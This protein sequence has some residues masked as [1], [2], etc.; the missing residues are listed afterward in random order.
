MAEPTQ[1]ATLKIQH[2]A[3]PLL[4]LLYLVV[5]L[6]HAALA[7][8]TTGPDE[9]AHYEYARFIAEH[10]R[11]PANPAERG[12]AGYK[13]DQPPLF[14]LIAALPA[15]W[16]DP[17]GPPFLKRV[18]DHPRRQLIERTRHA[19]GLYNTEDE[20]WPYRGE[21]LRWHVG[22][23]VAILFGAATV[24]VT[25]FTARD[26]FKELLPPVGDRLALGAAAVVAF[27]PR[28]ALTGS[29]LNYETTLAF[30]AALYVWLLVR[31]A[32]EGMA[33]GP[34]SVAN[35]RMANGR[36]A[37]EQP[38]ESPIPLRYAPSGG[39]IVSNLPIS[40]SPIPLLLLGLCLGLAITAK[41]SALIL[42]LETMAALWLFKRYY[43]GSWRRWLRSLLIT[44]VAALPAAGWWFGFIIYRFNTIAQDG[45]WVGLLRPLIAADASDA[46]T[47]QLLSFL[48]GGQA[49]FSGAGD[50]LDIGPPW[51]WATTLFRTFWVAGIETHT[52]LGRPGLLL[53]LGLCLLAAYGLFMSW[54]Q[55]N[56]RPPTAGR[57]HQ[58]PTLPA[59]RSTLSQSQLLLALLLLHCAAA[60]VFP[61]IR[62]A[63]TFSLAD[64]AQGRH[65]LFL[66]APAF[67][68][69]LVWGVAG[70]RVAG[71][72]VAGSRVAGS[73]VAGSRVAGSKVAGSRVA[74]SRLLP[75]PYS[76]LPTP[77]SLLPTPYSSLLPPLFL[78]LW[79]GVQLWTMSWAYLPP[80]PVSTR[81]EA[82]TQVERR[83]DQA[84]N[85]AV[86]LVGY[87][88]QQAGSLLRLDLLWQA[89]AV[90]P[91]DYL[92]Q[93]SLLDP[94]G[95][96]AAQWLGYPAAGR[97]PSRAWDVGDLVRDTVWLSL[98]GLEAGIYRLEVQLL[99]ATLRQTAGVRP[100]APVSMGEFNLQAQ[101]PLSSP[102]FQIWRQGRPVTTPQTFHYRETILVTLE[103]GLAQSERQVNIV[104]AQPNLVFEPVRD[105]GDALLFQVGP[106]WPSGS[107]AV[108]V[109]PG[110]RVSEP[111]IQVV[112][113]WQ[114]RF[115]PPA[116]ARP[117]EANFANQVKLLG[118]ELGANRV[119]PGGGIPLTL[120]WQGLDWLGDDYTIFVKLLAADQ[121]VHGGRDRL[122]Q[123]GYRTLYWAPGEIVVDSFGAPVDP[124]APAGVY[125]LNVGLYQTVNGQAVSLPL[126]QDGQL[127]ET[128]S[129]NLG[130]VKVG[131]TPPGWT[132]AAAEPQVTLDQPFGAGPNL[133]LL[134]YDLTDAEGQPLQ[135]ATRNTQHLRLTLYWRSES[136]LPLDYTTFVHLRNAAGE[137]VAQQDQPP[138]GGVYP[139]SL[140]EPGE[141][142]A[143][144]ITLTL[145][146]ELPA[147][148]YELVIG[149]YD[150][151]TGQR[152]TVPGN[153]ENSVIVDVGEL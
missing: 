78:L 112:D 140:W 37:N 42:P 33:N 148:K 4:L 53:A 36:I 99:P 38:G 142:I 71:S 106:D 127:L 82:A 111:L 117:V 83:L 136:T 85:D 98:G 100:S 22:R 72:R 133:I 122:P 49:G 145:P 108:Q 147:G 121:T 87:S 16:V 79:S 45:L 118:Y 5:A 30:L 152:L 131:S 54:R 59:P 90:S 31:M 29:M 46:T 94:Q 91:V 67:A 65:I 81:S 102:P 13:S 28:Y 66:T 56:A 39:T 124:D 119:E 8:L 120:Y 86:T 25:Y 27:I 110:E 40:Q 139:T 84:L 52:P 15:G 63:A 143:D 80:L 128:S 20:Q 51:A 70:S 34:R 149:L 10:G 135:H 141:L 134:G 26:V 57:R 96:V 23:W 129:L 146:A 89:A 101:R 18:S 92:T 47:N 132:V 126:M 44:G 95:R 76:L 150:F 105:L 77:Y 41:L 115:D 153:A 58:N 116:I 68:I 62:Y 125:F 138:L 103:P 9:L 61:L 35:E 32:N 19:W 7:P 151:Q 114:R 73:R 12:Q 60:F 109:T 14:H 3:L 74:G 21:V 107:Y 55:S 93:V 144:E 97:Y 88:R 50:N 113:R 64:T 17:T 43:G 2:F 123:E 137:T 104:G 48:T 130:P 1:H 69:L 24:A 6:A 75:T 11:L